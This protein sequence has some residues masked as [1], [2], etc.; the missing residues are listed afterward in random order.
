MAKKKTDDTSSTYTTTGSSSVRGG[1]RSASSTRV[2]KAD[3][4][5]KN[6]RAATDKFLADMR[7]KFHA[8]ADSPN[9]SLKREMALDDLKFYVGSL[10]RDPYESGQWPAR[11]QTSHELDASQPTFTVGLPS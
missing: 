10:G 3:S 1:T 6:K 5:V 4:E 8:I 9:E 7:S 11:R 2:K